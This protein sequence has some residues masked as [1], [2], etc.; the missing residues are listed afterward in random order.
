MNRNVANQVDRESSTT[1]TISSQRSGNSE[2]G[3]AGLSSHGTHV[4]GT[5]AGAWGSNDPSGVAGV[6]GP[7]VGRKLLSCN[8]FGRNGDADGASISDIVRCLAH[9]RQRNSH[10]VVNLSLGGEWARTDAAVALLRQGLNT[11]VCDAGGIAIVA[12]H[13]YGVNVDNPNNNKAVYPAAFA[14][15]EVPCLV[16]VASIDQG[17]ALS[18]FS[19]F[20][21]AVK[22]AAPV[23]MLLLVLQLQVVGLPAGTRGSNLCCTLRL[24]AAPHATH[25][26][27]ITWAATSS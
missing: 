3:R 1:I 6:L 5:I 11:H 18:S 26:V 8:V 23:S 20:G 25:G 16:A 9:A 7:A 17:D 13:N 24:T 10:W 27:V 14:G 22:I 15:S 12:A 4:F 19:N 2:G 21:T